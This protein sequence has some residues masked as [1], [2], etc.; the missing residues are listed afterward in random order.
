MSDRI[1]LIYELH[2]DA[3]HMLVGLLLSKV[4]KRCAPHMW[5]HASFYAAWAFLSIKHTQ[6]PYRW[7]SVCQTWSIWNYM[8]CISL[9]FKQSTNQCCEVTLSVPLL[10]VVGLTF[11]I[12]SQTWYC[13]FT[14]LLWKV[15][16]QS[17]FK[18][19]NQPKIF[20]QQPS[21]FPCLQQPLQNADQH[22]P[23]SIKLCF[24]HWFKSKMPY[25][26]ISHTS[27][28]HNVCCMYQQ[29]CVWSVWSGQPLSKNISRRINAWAQQS[30]ID[31]V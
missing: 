31:C 5:I 9:I 25:F 6:L 14:W 30:N 8:L 4:R 19:Q 18:I 12:A 21:I 29:Q 3:F 13:S 17:G 28:Q 10:V 15:P 20:L 11:L 26:P 1:C 27:F 16:S 22:V 24:H 23:Y 2:L 7:V